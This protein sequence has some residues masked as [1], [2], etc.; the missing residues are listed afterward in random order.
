ML[1]ESVSRIKEIDVTREKL[2]LLKETYKEKRKEQIFKQLDPEA[3][4]DQT[5]RTISQSFESK[6]GRIRD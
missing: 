3:M 2:N 6:I 1:A 4:L 5:L